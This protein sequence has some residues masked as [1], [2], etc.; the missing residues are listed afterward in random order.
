MRPQQSMNGIWYWLNGLHAHLPS[1]TPTT[2]AQDEW[3]RYDA[4]ASR[5]V[6]ELS[7]ALT[8]RDALNAL[9]PASAVASAAGECSATY[10]MRCCFISEYPSVYSAA[11]IN[12]LCRLAVIWQ[13]PYWIQTHLQHVG[14]AVNRIMCPSLIALQARTA[15]S[16]MPPASLRGTR[17]VAAGQQPQLGHRWGGAVKVSDPFVAAGW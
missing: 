10:S 8:K 7:A 12:A 17:H 14:C 15:S 5:L 6:E 1:P 9:H 3:A 11:S 2:P 16:A 4:T 13:L